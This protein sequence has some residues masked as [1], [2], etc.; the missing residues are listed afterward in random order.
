MSNSLLTRRRV[1]I[2]LLMAPV[3]ALGV[4]AYVS[5]QRTAELVHA[6]VLREA[7][8]SRHVVMESFLRE[9]MNMLKLQART[10]THG[11]VAD[12]SHL[13]DHLVALRNVYGDFDGLFV[14]DDQGQVLETAGDGPLAGTDVSAE[15]WF[16]EA[17][18]RGAHLGQM[19]ADANGNPS[20]ILA[21]FGT[22]EDASVVL[23][24]K[25]RLDRLNEMLNE[26]EVWGG[27]GTYLVD[28]FTGRY[29]SAPYF[30]GQPYAEVNSQFNF[31]KRHF[32]IDYDFHGLEEVATGHYRNPAGDKV[33]EAHCCVHSGEWLVVVERSLEA[34]QDLIRPLQREFLTVGLFLLV[35]VGLGWFLALRLMERSGPD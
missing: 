13:M 23:G 10:H 3:I 20:I 26:F 32:H 16:K 28:P 4:Y 12:H 18:L 6:E 8:E 7:V 5:Y 1:L 24:A 31:G 33:M 34:T 21:A 9:R 11:H 14:I 27:G 25:M 17:R 29:L 2:P 22:D 19:V 30:G 35:S 15:G